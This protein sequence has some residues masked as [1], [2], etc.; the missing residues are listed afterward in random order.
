MPF[1][2]VSYCADLVVLLHEGK[3]ALAIIA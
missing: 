3:P 1:M 2:S